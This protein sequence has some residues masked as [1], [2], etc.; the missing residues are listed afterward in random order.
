[1]RAR[2]QSGLIL[3][4]FLIETALKIFPLWFLKPWVR[5]IFARIVAAHPEISER[6]LGY[7]EK[8]LMLCPDGHEIAFL[9]KVKTGG[10][11]LELV[12]KN[13]VDAGAK[14]SG[15]MASL[16]ELGSG[17]IGG[18]ALFFCRDLFLEGETSLVVALRNAVDGAKVRPIYDLIKGK[19]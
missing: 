7:E 6:L 4:I 15:K 10:A 3:V 2:P 14:V 19:P 11:T 18:D 1:M 12:E 9:L 8:S 5:I 13:Q 16:I 17:K